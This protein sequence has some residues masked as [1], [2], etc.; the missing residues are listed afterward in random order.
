MKGTMISMLLL[1]IAGA[2]GV[3][4]LPLKEGKPLFDWREIK[5]P[6]MPDMAA[7]K[8]LSDDLGLDQLGD[9][10]NGGSDDA[11]VPPAKVKV[12]R[13][14]DA[15]GN[16]QFS[17]EPPPTGVQFAEQNINPNTNVIRSIPVDDAPAP[18]PSRSASVASPTEDTRPSPATEAAKK[19]EA[20]SKLPGPYGD[21]V[22]QALEVQGLVDKHKAEQDRISNSF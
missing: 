10:V 5:G 2:A 22:G 14:Q 8:E 6:E 9:R 11:Y 13:W 19:A 18:Q 4:L 21:A 3:F 1:L 20:L 12:Y 16:W 17:N 15:D 7:V